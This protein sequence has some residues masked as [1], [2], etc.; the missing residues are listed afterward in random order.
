[1]TLAIYIFA[2][3]FGPAVVGFM[4]ALIVRA[5]TRRRS[6]APPVAR[7]VRAWTI[8]GLLV[9]VLSELVR[10]L[11]P[12]PPPE[13][14][15]DARFAAPLVGGIVAV[16]LL[17][18]PISRRSMRGTAALSRRTL[19][20]FGSRWWLI[21]LLTLVAIVLGITAAAGA[22][23]QPDNLGHYRF[24]TI[25]LGGVT[26][27]T[28]IYGWYYSVPALVLLG[29]LVLA[30]L[31]VVASVARP[32]LAA[33]D[34]TDAA[35]RHWRTRNI[36]AVAGGAVLLHLSTILWSLAGTA[37][38]HGGYSTPAG[39]V[40]AGTPFAV[41]E[42]PLQVTSVMAETGGWFLWLVVLLMAAFPTARKGATASWRSASR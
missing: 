38:L 23:S 18:L 4:A 40:G 42:T 8:V 22:A 13:A 24:Y 37:M 39:F 17:L 11:L 5:I 41:L 10:R 1:M 20:S 3:E 31:I 7:A 30:V 35:T 9:A 6:S 15:M 33:D 25:E 32:P 19:F 14:L 2:F 28:R 16:V 21:A 29:L 27:G 26:M 36:F 34:V 12:Y